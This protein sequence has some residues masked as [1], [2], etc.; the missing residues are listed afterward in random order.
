MDYGDFK[1]LPKRAALDKS[2]RDKAFNNAES[3][4]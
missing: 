4:K 1:Y 3:P 2:L